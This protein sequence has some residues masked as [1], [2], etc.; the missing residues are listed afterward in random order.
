MNKYRKYKIS[1]DYVNIYYYL[2][3]NSF[4]EN[5]IKNLRKE[6]GFIKVNNNPVNIRHPLRR[7]DV[8]EINP[9]PNNKT[10]IMQYILPLNIVYEDEYYLL[11]Y[12]DSGIS[13]MP[14]KSHYTNNLSG[15]I[16]NY[17]YKKDKNFTLR[18]INR[19]DKD[20]SGIIIVAK[21]S[22]SQKD[23]KIINKT[24]E[25]ICIGEITSPI[26]IDKKIKTTNINGIN[27]IKRIISFAENQIHVYC[28]E[29][30]SVAFGKSFV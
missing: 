5:Y 24:Y 15:A 6:F 26:V 27:N 2:K 8:L 28:A 16:C 17:M 14:T 12:K 30:I 13:C 22:I 20:T 10:C 29:N 7:G 18:I 23:L 25:A 4:S 3:D 9:S 11:V 19:L 1:K 21:D